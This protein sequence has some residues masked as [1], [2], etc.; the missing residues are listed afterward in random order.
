MRI[1]KKGWVMSLVLVMTLILTACGGA[2][3]AAS[4]APSETPTA[5][6][7]GTTAPTETPKAAETPAA[8]KI[9]VGMVTDVGGVNDNSFNQSA[10]EG[11]QAF[12]KDNTSYLQS[13]SDADYVPNLNTFAKQ[14]TDLTWGIGF[15]IA[16]AI[17]KVADENPNLKFAIIDGEVDA[18]NVTS[19]LFKEHEGSFL[20]GV[21]AGLTTKSNKIGFVGGMKIPVIERF[22]AGFV[23]GVKAANPDAKVEVVYTGKFDSPSEGKA[24]AA[25]LFGKGVDVMFHAAGATGDGVF[26]E[27]KERKKKDPNIWV[28]GVDK[29][30]AKT[31]GDEITLTSMM[32]YVD[33]AVKSVSTDFANGKFE[34]KVVNLGLKENGVGLPPKNPNVSA[35]ILKKVEE[36]Q[37]KIISGEIIVPETPSK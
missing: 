3:P 24:T 17:K 6:P 10:W 28:I 37:A 25:A 5:T 19:V 27:A 36:F 18:K 16:D 32:K 22:E 9:K 33:V 21:V 30:Q 15:V 29:D 12:D 35:D 1:Q 2:K 14:G 13:T 26:N 31:F 4:S 34:G 23:A 7:A 11:L 20:V 8:G